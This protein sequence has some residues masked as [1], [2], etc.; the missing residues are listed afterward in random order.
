MNRTASVIISSYNYAPYLRAAIDSALA[1]THPLSEVIVVDD[2]STDESPQVIRSYGERVRAILKANAGQASCLNEGFSA[3]RGDV[4]LFVD[5]DDV[6]EPDAVRRALEAMAPGVSKAHW[7]LREIDPAGRVLSKV[8]PRAAVSSGDLR[9]AV[10]ARGPSGEHYAWPPTSGNAWA[11]SYLERVMPMPARYRTCPDLYL[12]ALAPLYGCVAAVR[13]PLG[14]WRVHG[15]NNTW[16]GWFLDRLEHYV[17]L[18]DEACADLEGHA[19]GLGLSPDPARWRAES[20][21]HRLRDAARRVDAL[22]PAGAPFVLIDDDQWGCNEVGRRRALPLVREGGPPADDTH[23]IAAL[24]S[25]R[26]EGV[27]HLVLAWAAFWWTDYYRH[28][29]EHL[30]S[31]SVRIADDESIVVHEL[32]GA[33]GA[34][35]C[36]N[37]R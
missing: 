25:R 36:M 30:L 32:R 31:T 9:Q 6:L 22:L 37:P 24:E 15:Q 27:R 18:W 33:G 1:Q 34:N 21:W 29:A 12:C 10:L 11:R 17:R 19:R 16:K 8:V 7:P 26:T 3:S 2:G 13:S 5:S 28:F 20:W 4:V 23:A 35:R 14:R